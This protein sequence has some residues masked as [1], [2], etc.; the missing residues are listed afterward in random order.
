MK[1]QKFQK[2]TQSNLNILTP[3]LVWLEN[4]PILVSLGVNPLVTEVI[5]TEPILKTYLGTNILTFLHLGLDPVS[6]YCYT[7]Y[8]S[9]RMKYAA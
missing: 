4:A 3:E 7:Y 1:P 5:E 8:K 6:V 2:G 9:Q